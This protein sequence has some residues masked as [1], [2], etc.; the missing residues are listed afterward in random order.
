MLT[1]LLASLVTFH[2]RS[3]ARLRTQ[4]A[5]SPR[6]AHF[7]LCTAKHV[8]YKG[9]IETSQSIRE[10][11]LGILQGR[12]WSEVLVRCAR[13]LPIPAGVVHTVCTHELQVCVM[14]VFTT[15]TRVCDTTRHSDPKLASKIVDEPAFKIPKGERCGCRCPQ[16]PKAPRGL[17]PG[18]HC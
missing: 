6:C 11:N 17:Q 13:A 7:C 16:V 14:A 1:T 12:L 8:G 10:R 15:S 5:H 9:S 2:F 18:S 3:L 4:R